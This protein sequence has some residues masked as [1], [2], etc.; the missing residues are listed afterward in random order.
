MLNY[1]VMTEN[2]Q[3][4]TENSQE[5][6]QEVDT[7][8]VQAG[9]ISNLENLEPRSSISS[10]NEQRKPELKSKLSK[11]HSPNQRSNWSKN[12][13]KSEQQ[14][15]YD[16]Y[17]PPPNTRYHRS[18]R[19]FEFNKTS[20]HASIRRKKFAN[21]KQ[22]S[23][24]NLGDNRCTDYPISFINDEQLNVNKNNLFVNTGDF[25]VRRLSAPSSQEANENQ[26][27][28]K[29][30][31][32]PLSQQHLQQHK[33]S[34]LSQQ[35]L[36]NSSRRSSRPHNARKY[37]RWNTIDNASNIPSIMINDEHLNLP[38][39]L[40]SLS[41]EQIYY[42]THNLS[43]LNLPSKTTSRQAS[44]KSSS[45]LSPKL[46]NELYNR[47]GTIQ[48][49][50]SAGNNYRKSFNDELD[51]SDYHELV[52]SKMKSAQD[53]DMIPSP[54]FYSTSKSKNPRRFREPK[55]KRNPSLPANIG[56]P[57]N[58]SFFS[59]TMQPT[60]KNFSF[61]S[62]STSNESSLPN[63]DTSWI[64][65]SSYALN[66]SSR[67]KQ[68]S[69][70]NRKS[71]AYNYFN[72]QPLPSSSKKQLRCCSAKSFSNDYP[73]SPQPDNLRNQSKLTSKLSSSSPT[74]ASSSP[75][76]SDLNHSETKWRNAIESSN[77]FANLR[78]QELYKPSH[79][80]VTLKSPNK[81]VKRSYSDEKA[82]TNKRAYCFQ[83]VNVRRKS[84]SFDR[85]P[86][87]EEFVLI[88]LQ[89]NQ[90][91]K[92]S[93]LKNQSSSDTAIEPVQQ[94]EEQQVSFSSESI[95]DINLSKNS[96]KIKHI[97]NRQ[98]ST[99]KSHPDHNSDKNDNNASNQQPSFDLNYFEAV[100]YSKNIT[101][102][103]IKDLA[104]KLDDVKLKEADD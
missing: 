101:E 62:S 43:F 50:L 63:L 102:A 73:T 103:D 20:P 33:L 95:Q 69:P 27:L 52:L 57:S 80:R 68:R 2:Y 4:I 28:Q 79:L 47:S 48:K 71:T 53:F 32:L 98:V 24:V 17:S 39:H 49:S 99:S 66:T 37:S 87:E 100:N 85:S 70:T 3:V 15:N 16:F 82:A 22:Y 90:K 6:E 56:Q 86:T 45:R 83:N 12:R 97:L 58:F 23:C 76:L 8:S 88:P 72:F 38:S 77:F 46:D 7:A 54:F 92:A 36:D 1:Q 29:Q 21:S 59:R 5:D 96:I 60:D 13:A 89:L 26:L 41:N 42:G 30:R 93:K 74:T 44:P 35:S 64:S 40:E 25:P 61:S 78:T 81:L 19:F 75:S 91:L 65:N 51:K 9:D 55:I 94:S 34:Q 14:Y 84:K 31:Q 18:D 10:G 11:S 67:K 104:R